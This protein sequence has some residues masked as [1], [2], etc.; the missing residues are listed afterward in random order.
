[1]SQVG[2]LKMKLSFPRSV[3]IDLQT[4]MVDIPRVKSTIARKGWSLGSFVILPNK[5][6]QSSLKLESK[7]K[8]HYENKN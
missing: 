2:E 1:M 7:Q 6:D 3:S 8:K 5:Q 4:R